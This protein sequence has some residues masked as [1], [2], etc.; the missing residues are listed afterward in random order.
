[1]GQSCS[2]QPSSS[3]YKPNT[4]PA[5]EGHAIS[6]PTAAGAVNPKTSSVEQEDKVFTPPSLQVCELL[7]VTLLCLSG[8]RVSVGGAVCVGVCANVQ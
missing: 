2:S 3:G 8:G 6:S 7:R 4:Q 1:M 5:Q